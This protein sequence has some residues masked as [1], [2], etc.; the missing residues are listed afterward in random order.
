MKLGILGGTFNPIHY[1]HLRIAE[2]VRQE[3]GLERV[4]F[5]PAATPPHKPLAGDLPFAERAAMVALAIQGNP[6][7][8][9]CDTEGRRGGTSWLIDTLRQLKAEYPAD[10]LHFI[11]GSDSF[12]DIGRWKE[13]GEYLSLVSLVVAERP[14]VTTRQLAKTLPDDLAKVLTWDETG[15]RL[16]HPRGTSVS[17]FRGTLLDISSSSIRRLVESGSSISYLVP[18]KVARFIHEK[19]LYSD[20]R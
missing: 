19:R 8:S 13:Y 18:E 12:A 11:M 3:Y 20:A 14:G 7:F 17:F 2:E 5:M 10:E 1:G 15:R 6:A 9:L 16:M 4:L